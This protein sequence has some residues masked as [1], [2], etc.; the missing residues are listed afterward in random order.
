MERRPDPA[1]GG[2]SGSG[3]NTTDKVH[4]VF[5]MDKPRLVSRRMRPQ[6][7]RGRPNTAS[8]LQGEKAGNRDG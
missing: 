8:S 6:D 7:R 1:I 3:R 2:E 4:T 5:V